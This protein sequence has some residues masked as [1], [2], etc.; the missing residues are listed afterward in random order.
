MKTSF[1][2]AAALVATLAAPV[3][4]AAGAGNA[5][6]LKTQQQ[7][8]STVLLDTVSASTDGTVAIVD[9]RNGVAGETLG[10]VPVNAGTSTDVKVS[11]GRLVNNGDVIAVLYNEFGDIVASKKVDVER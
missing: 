4:F 3:A 6:S 10:S 2:L 8:Y 5:I 7:V 11:V 9:Y 1:T